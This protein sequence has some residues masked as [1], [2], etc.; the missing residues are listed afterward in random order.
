VIGGSVFAYTGNVLWMAP[1]AAIAIVLGA[2]IR[3]RPAP[4]LT[5]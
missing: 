2:V 4:S 3:R 5:R 1:V